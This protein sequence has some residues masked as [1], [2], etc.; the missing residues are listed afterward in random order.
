MTLGDGDTG[1][2][3]GDVGSMMHLVSFFIERR[4]VKRLNGD[5]YTY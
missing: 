2:D 1:R 3:G 5:T 4:L